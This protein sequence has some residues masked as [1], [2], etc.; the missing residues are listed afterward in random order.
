[1]IYRSGERE[2][3]RRPQWPQRRSKKNLNFAV[4]AAFC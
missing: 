4:F 1:L 2:R 3:D